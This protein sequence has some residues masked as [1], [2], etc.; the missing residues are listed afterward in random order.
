[1]FVYIKNIHDGQANFFLSCSVWTGCESRRSFSQLFGGVTHR[2]FAERCGPA[3]KS[4]CLHHAAVGSAVPVLLD[5]GASAT[6]HTHCRRP[7]N[8]ET[9]CGAAGYEVP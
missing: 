8:E 5:S 1:V 3:S 7:V 2:D 9:I 6:D 4:H